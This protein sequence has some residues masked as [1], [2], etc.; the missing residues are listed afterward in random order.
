[1]SPDF[2]EFFITV[3]IKFDTATRWESRGSGG[4]VCTEIDGQFGLESGGQFDRFFQ[5]MH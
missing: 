2:A 5:L 3:I 4:S 1:M